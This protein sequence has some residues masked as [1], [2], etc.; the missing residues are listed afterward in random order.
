MRKK[1]APS[2]RRRS[3]G[4]L[5]LRDAARGETIAG[6][7]AGKRTGAASACACV[8][9]MKNAGRQQANLRQF[10]IIRPHGRL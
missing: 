3:H 7:G 10:A 8:G 9:V 2:S 6:T 1:R 4:I 5:H